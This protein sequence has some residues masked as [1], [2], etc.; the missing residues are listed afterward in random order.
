MSILP[1]QVISKSLSNYLRVLKE[2][3]PDGGSFK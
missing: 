1:L 3:I 2:Q